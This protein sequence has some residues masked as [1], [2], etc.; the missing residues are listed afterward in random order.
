MR[1]WLICWSGVALFLLT[2][3]IVV[4]GTFGWL[5]PSQT[6]A[7]PAATPNWTDKVV[8]IG[9]AIGAAGFIAAA[10]GA[11]VAYDQL[12]ETRRDR[13]LQVIME[14]GRRWDDVRLSRARQALL[15]YTPSTLADHI[16]KC[17]QKASGTNLYVILRVPNFYEDLAMVADSGLDLK[18]VAKHFGPDLITEW[19][20]WEESITEVLQKV[21]PDA[22]CEFAALVDKVKLINAPKK[23]ASKATKDTR[24]KG[25]DAIAATAAANAEAS[26]SCRRG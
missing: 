24:F 13:F 2:M 25:A 9:T 5:S 14:F 26:A 16:R 23:A 4:A 8:A 3:E 18:T 20:F 19:A 12:K 7:R 10:V 15:P 21:D 6:G 1:R 22:Y 17:L 11:F